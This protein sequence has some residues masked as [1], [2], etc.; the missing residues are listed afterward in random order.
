MADQDTG[1]EP[2]RLPPMSGPLKWVVSVLGAASL[3]LA[4][5]SFIG[6]F[7]VVQEA[8]RPWHHHQSWMI[9]VGTDLG[10]IVTIAWNIVFKAIGMRPR[11][12]RLVTWLFIGLQMGL[13]VGAAHGDP[14][15]S[16]SDVVLP[17]LFV[18]LAEILQF[19]IRMHRKRV[20]AS[21][22]ERIPPAR[23]LADWRGSRDLRRRMI[24][25]DVNK[26]SEALDM[27]QQA[28]RAEASLAVMYG[29]G[30]R[31]KAP[32][33]LLSL[34]N[35]K[36]YLDEACAE[37]KRLR[38]EYDK[39]NRNTGMQQRPVAAGSN[40]ESPGEA[41][42]NPNAERRPSEKRTCCIL[43]QAV[44]EG[45]K[46]PKEEG[47]NVRDDHF[48]AHGRRPGADILQKAVTCSIDYARELCREP[49]GSGAQS[50]HASGSQ[51]GASGHTGVGQRVGAGS[52]NG[53][54]AAAGR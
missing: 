40:V 44:S 16:L 32:A 46:L 31:K 20:T 33:D 35:T 26:Y 52:M 15:G 6:M 23:F 12:L 19:F 17:S 51:S 21:E 9:P 50:G 54:S 14:L 11:G 53:S 38:T 29:P 49:D 30:W 18:V 1:R 43:H 41:N 2:G 48:R 45:A 34:L 37:I 27:Q 4:V 36:K 22:R 47:R 13:N 10:I 42:G 25:W 7:S 5:M 28:L 3:A 24:L 8:I 39:Q